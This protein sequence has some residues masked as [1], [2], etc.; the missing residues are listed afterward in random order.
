MPPGTTT[1]GTGTLAVVNGMDEA[2]LVISSLSA[3]THSITAK[4][5]G[6]KTF[7]PSTSLALSQVVNQAA[8]TT[9][10]SVA[11]TGYFG[12]AETIT[13]TVTANSPS[14]ATPVGSAD[15]FDTTTNND[16]GTVT[17]SASGVSREVVPVLCREDSAMSRLQLAVVRIA[18]FARSGRGAGYNRR[19]G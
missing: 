10:G 15:F 5:G 7:S 3:G 6:D 9:A 8:T 1:L 13:A 19:S 17:L 11:G 18:R 4:Y 16:L 12:T 2:T 14:T